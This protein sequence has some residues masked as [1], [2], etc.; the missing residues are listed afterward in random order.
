MFNRKSS[1][2]KSSRRRTEVEINSRKR[3]PYRNEVLT[4]SSQIDD[5]ML[6]KRTKHVSVSLI[7][8]HKIDEK[9][10]EFGNTNPPTV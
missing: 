9:V 3:Y 2:L 1:V 5:S 10:N 4:N 8:S 7:E 6:R